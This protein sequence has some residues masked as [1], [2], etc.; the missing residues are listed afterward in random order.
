MEKGDIIEFTDG[1]MNGIRKDGTYSRIYLILSDNLFRIH[2]VIND[3]D[4]EVHN[5]I[6]VNREEIRK[7]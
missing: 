3:G 1:R 2:T 7:I 5:Y 6:N 4:K